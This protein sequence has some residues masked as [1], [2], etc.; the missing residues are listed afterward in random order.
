[1]S[2]IITP[3]FTV[4]VIALL[5]HLWAKLVLLYNRSKKNYIYMFFRYLFLV[6]DLCIEA[7]MLHDTNFNFY[8]SNKSSAFS[9]FY[10]FS[11]RCVSIQLVTCCIFPVSQSEQPRCAFSRV[12]ADQQIAGQYGRE[13]PDR[14]RPVRSDSPS[15]AGSC[16]RQIPQCEDSGCVGHDA[17]A[18][19]SRARLPHHQR[20]VFVFI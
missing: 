3:V 11:P 1:M 8:L 20:F 19:A 5:F 9:A 16:Q 12:P 10:I 15:D 4:V 13:R 2:I 14:R 6:L 18:A 7:L 17:S